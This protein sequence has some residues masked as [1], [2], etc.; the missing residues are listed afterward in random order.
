MT[1]RITATR[2]DNNGVRI[3]DNSIETLGDAACREYDTKREAQSV[4]DELTDS[5]DD[6]GMADAKYEVVEA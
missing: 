6:Y 5:R 1:Y 4:A 3:S 2:I